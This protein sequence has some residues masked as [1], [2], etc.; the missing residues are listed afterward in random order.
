MNDKTTQMDKNVLKETNEMSLLE[1]FRSSPTAIGD[2]LIMTREVN[3][4]CN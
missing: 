2:Y 4:E 1:Y 3:V